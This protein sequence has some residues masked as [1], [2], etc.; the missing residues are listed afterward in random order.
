LIFVAFLF[1]LAVYC[2]AL[3][4]VNRRQHPLM[5]SAAWDFAGLLFAASGLLAF[6]VP[7]FLNSFSEHG[8]LLAM[9]GRPAAADEGSWGWLGDLFGGLGSTLF[10]VGTGPVL[11]VYF[12]VVVAGCASILWRRQAETAVYNVHSD[13]FD[14]VLAGV[15]DAAGLMWSHAANRYLIRRV[16][17]KDR[18]PTAEAEPDACL[19]VDLAPALRH[20]TLRWETNDEELRKQVE[21]ELGHALADVWTRDNPVGTWLLTA[22]A[23]FLSAAVMIFVFVVVYRLL[24]R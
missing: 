18:P 22:G 20:A 7:G 6:G 8:R 2:L 13:V 24:G 21:G 4:A 3:G 14:E 5:V 19:E 11:V 9:F 17:G 16:G 10:V 23:A 15:L 12:V 1:P